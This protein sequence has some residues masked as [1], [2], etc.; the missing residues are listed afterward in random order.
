[1][2]YASH[3]TATAHENGDCWPDTCP[4][5]ELDQPA[6]HP[7][8]LILW[9]SGNGTTRAECACGWQGTRFDDDG[10]KACAEHWAHREGER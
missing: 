1:M 6:P 7:H 2:T 9:A 4:I 8:E 5:C 3:T 10:T